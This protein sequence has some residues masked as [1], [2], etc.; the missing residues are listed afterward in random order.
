MTSRV[1]TGVSRTAVALR[2]REWQIR[3][4]RLHTVMNL[5]PSHRLVRNRGGG[6]VDSY[7]LVAEPTGH[8]LLH[9]TGPPGAL[10]QV[11]LNDSR[12]IE[13][14]SSGADR[15]TLRAEGDPKDSTRELLDLLRQIL[16]VPESGT[17]YALALDR[18][19]QPQDGVDPRL[20]SNTTLGQMIY[21]G[22]YLLNHPLDPQRRSIGANLADQLCTV[23]EMHPLLTTIDAIIAV[24]GHDPKVRSFGE[25]LAIGVAQRRSIPLIRCSK[26]ASFQRAAKNMD[27][28][29]RHAELANSFTCRA[30]QRVKSALIIDDVY[31]TG[32]TTG[33]AARAAKASGVADVAA[34][35]VVRTTSAPRSGDV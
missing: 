21:R 3:P 9:L 16:T 26:P 32:T 5:D 13:I 12:Y 6:C 33:E 11:L 25:Q 17:A 27:P 10:T 23:I 29:E 1:V 14:S 30:T 18:Y 22:K 34:L 8:H 4:E 2:E 31:E 19:K 20:W 28:D 35:C 15:H 7:R 24:P